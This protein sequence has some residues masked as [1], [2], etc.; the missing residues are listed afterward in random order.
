MKRKR[1]IPETIKL[2]RRTFDRRKKGFDGFSVFNNQNEECA[3]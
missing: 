3:F 2:I 1:K